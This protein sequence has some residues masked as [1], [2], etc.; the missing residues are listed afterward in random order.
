MTTI[1]Q[2]LDHPNAANLMDAYFRRV[3]MLSKNP[4]LPS[5]L[6]FML[7]DVMDL[8]QN[9][10]RARRPTDGPKTIQEVHKDAIMERVEMTRGAGRD[11]RRDMR[12][13]DFPRQMQGTS[14]GG[15]RRGGGPMGPPPGLM[16][17]PGAVGNAM[18][19]RH[20]GSPGNPPPPCNPLGPNGGS[21]GLS[22]PIQ[23]VY[24][25]DNRG[26]MNAGP[27]PPAPFQS[28]RDAGPS[29]P[30]TASRPVLEVATPVEDTVEDAAS[31]STVDDNKEKL[32]LKKKAK[33][34]L[35]E[36]YCSPLLSEVELCIKEMCPVSP[37]E[38]GSVIVSTWFEGMR[39]R[40]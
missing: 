17:P 39:R 6:R 34:T 38:D 1:G 36:Y 5:R 35:E 26:S 2:R 29:L 18:M 22:R 3:E 10:W 13:H 20:G 40:L 27:P 4:K 8:R 25:S 33:A 37:E 24:G 30:A 12:R 21:P 28:R 23:G 19:R 14:Y 16:G 32:A 15:D 9:R 11:P 31:S 7:Q